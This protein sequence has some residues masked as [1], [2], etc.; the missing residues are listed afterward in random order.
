MSMVSNMVDICKIKISG[1]YGMLNY[2]DDLFSYLTYHAVSKNFKTNECRIVSPSYVDKNLS[3]SEFKFLN[4]YYNQF[5]FKGKISR[6]VNYFYSTFNTDYY[7]FSGGSLFSNDGVNIKDIV[8]STNYNRYKLHAMGVSIGPYKSIAA[9][10]NNIEKLKLY[11]Y[12]AVRDKKSFARLS[13]YNL[14]AKIVLAGDLA[15]LGGDIF[16]NS[17]FLN[18]KINNFILGFSPCNLGSFEDSKKYVENFLKTTIL[19][20]KKNELEV[21]LLCLNDNPYNGDD[22]LCRYCSK[23]LTE[24]N[25]THKIINYS[26]IGV[27]E[28]WNLIASLDFYVSVRLHGAITAYL[29]KVPFFLYEYHEKCTEFLDFI[30]MEK[31]ITDLVL[32]DPRILIE[33]IQRENIDLLS[34]ESF[35][36]MSKLNIIESPLYYKDI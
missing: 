34:V 23:I 13:S 35:S 9:E 20:N 31:E 16:K 5:N 36:N 10:K 24:N 14:D 8:Y 17:Q 4:A 21:Y 11:E 2:G 22:V 18:R 27:E 33:K 28:T 19:L 30:G 32:E 3:Y 1:Y 6:L 29:N 26:K 25:I 12:I 15:G 7:I